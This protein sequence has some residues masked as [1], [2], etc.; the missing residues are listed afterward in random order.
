MEGTDTS[1]RDD[2]SAQTGNG[3][4]FPLPLPPPRQTAEPSTRN[5]SVGEEDSSRP[6]WLR[7]SPE[8]LPLGSE[9]VQR[10]ASNA[11]GRS[12]GSTGNQIVQRTSSQLQVLS[13]SIARGTNKAFEA[14]F[15]DAK[16]PFV[17]RRRLADGEAAR[18]IVSRTL[19]PASVIFSQPTKMTN[20]KA[21]DSND[22]MEASKSLRAFS[23][24][25][26]RQAKCLAQAWT[27]PRMEPFANHPLFRLA[28]LD[29]D[30]DKA[31]ALYATG[32]INIVC[33]FGNVKGELFY[34]VHACVLGESLSILRWLV[35]ENCCPIK[36]VRVNGRTKDGICNYTAIVTS[37]GR[38]LLGIAM[39]NN[40]I[41]IVRYLVVEKGLSLAEEKSL[42]RETLVQNLQL[43][44]RAIPNATTSTE[45]IEM[46]VSEALYHDATV[47]DSAEAD[48]GDT[49][50]PL[51]SE[52][53]NVVPVPIPDREQGSERD[54][55]GGRT[56]SEE[57]RN[58][59]AISRP[60]RGSFSYDGRQDE[61]E[62]AWLPLAVIKSVVWTAASTCPVVQF[63]PCRPPSCEYLKYEK[64]KLRPKIFMVV[65]EL[66]F[67]SSSK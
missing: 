6:D 66:V 17:S 21:L 60:G 24:P 28:L 46:D 67:W 19:L 11:S 9:T 2:T 53:Q 38:S 52:Y 4:A 32:N 44:L 48:L 15:G 37:K 18:Y 1:F 3:S 7:D 16:P 14:L 27:P 33:P 10:E 58:F 50:S 36:S 39:E 62:F 61:N 41:P 26:E 35:D 40:L 30:Q 34:P 45:A 59:G 42:T 23:L 54:L 29:G 20:Q 12:A 63:A 25:S 31:V 49:T 5:S 56:L 43:A 65:Y 57:A 22:V 8:Q 13:S 51:S 64:K 55:P 47:N